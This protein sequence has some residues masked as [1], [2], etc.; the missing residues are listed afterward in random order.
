MLG[1]NS[2]DHL[3]DD[4]SADPRRGWLRQQQQ[5]LE[6]LTTIIPVEQ[7]STDAKVD[8]EI[9]RDDLVR[10]FWIPENTKP[11]EKDPRTYGA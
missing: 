4:I 5:T 6:S 2:L 3:L 11:F 9:F 10:G 7:L 8:F 1:E